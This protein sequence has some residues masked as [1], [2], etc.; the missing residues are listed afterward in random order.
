M[1][2]AIDTDGL[3]K[4]YGSARGVEDLTL[5]VEHGEVFGFLGPNGAGKTTTIRTLLGLLHPTAGSARILGLD[6]VRDG[7]EIRAR[8]GN[9]PGEFAYDPRMTGREVV[10]L[11]GALRG[12]RDLGPA[13]R[14]ARRL[15]AD[16]GRRLGDLS[17]GNRQKIGLIQALAHDP[18]LLV[19]DEPTGGL[20][21]L[22]QEEF[23]AIVAERRAAGATVFL[24]SH[25]LDE[26]QRVCDRVGIIRAGRLVAVEDVGEMRERAYRTV[27][28]RFGEPV[29]VRELRALEAVDALEE[30]GAVVRF[31][32][33]GDL[34]PVVKALGRHVVRDLE[35]TRPT[36]EELFLAY[37]EHTP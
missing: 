26:V 14:L 3:T 4:R 10:A 5:T 35:I 23:I 7:R 19:L 30:D 15:E 12:I 21:P 36:L 8:T 13:Q 2:A 34:D 37:Y 22:M 11:T 24:S 28:V 27:T 17:R 33:R 18:E 16:L 32:V 25:D 20:D 29:D 9:L 31:R 6:T 1:R